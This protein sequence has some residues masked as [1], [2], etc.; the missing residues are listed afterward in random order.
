MLNWDVIDTVLLD[1]DGTLLDLHFDNHFW[2]E[3]MPLRY[4]EIKGLDLEMARQQLFKQFANVA[5]T[6]DWYCLDYWRNT[7]ELDIVA[8]KHEVKHLITVQPFV[9]D[10]LRELRLREKKVVLVTNAHQASLKLK[11]EVTQLGGHFDDIISVHD[12]QIPKEKVACWSALQDVVAF[13]PRTTLLI[14]DNL[15]ALRTAREFGIKYLL[16]VHL[17]DTKRPRVDVA[18]FDAIDSFA[19][20]MPQSIG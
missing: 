17:P 2:L 4:A 8:L 12:F 20:I 5:G 6:L 19:E 11:M 15:S 10:F 14:D 3:H 9:L 7:L 18:E 13:D 16:A 1:M